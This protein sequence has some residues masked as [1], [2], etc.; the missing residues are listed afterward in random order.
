MPPAPAYSPDPD[1][2]KAITRVDRFYESG[3]QDRR[4]HEG[5]W[6][7]CTAAYRG[8]TEA[9][10]ND[11]EHRL[12]TPITPIRRRESRNRYQAKI[13]GRH[14]LFMRNPT[15]PEVRPATADHE[16]KQNARLTQKAL[17]YQ[18]RRCNVEQMYDEAL[19]WSELCSHGLLWLHWD[20]SVVVRGPNPLTQQVEEAQLGDIKLEVGS[21]FELLV[22]DPSIPYIGNQPAIMRCKIV[23]LD[24]LKAEYG[25][26]A[27]FI[28]PDSLDDD[29]HRNARYIA[30][31]AAGG[32]STA[33]TGQQLRTTSRGEKTS[34]DEPNIF[35]RVVRKEYFEAPCPLYP[36]G[37][38]AVVAGGVLLKE[39]YMLPEGF[40]D[41][42]NPYPV[43]DFPDMTVP[44]QF[45]GTTI[46]AQLL[47]TERGYNRAMDTIERNFRK[48]GAEKTVVDRRMKVNN[49]EITD[50]TNEVVVA[51]HLPGIPPIYK[52]PASPIIADAW[53]LIDVYRDQY[54][55]ISGIYPE[56]EGASGKSESGFQA[57]LLQEATSAIHQPD[58]NVHTR[59][60]VDLYRKMRRMMKNRYQATRLIS[61]GGHNS[62]PEVFEFSA[63]NIDEYADIVVETGSMLP[64]MK[65]ARLQ[66]LLELWGQGAF[67]PQNDPNAL[68]A[69]QKRLE[70]GRDD[71]SFDPQSTHEQNAHLENLRMHRGQDI[72]PAEFGDNHVLHYQIHVDDLVK[73]RMRGEPFQ[74]RLIRV[75][76]ILTHARYQNPQA[77][78]MIAAEYGLP[79]PPPPGAG[80]TLAANGAGQ[81]MPPGMPP[82]PSG[83]PPGGAPPPQGS[84]PQGPPGPPQG[85]PLD[86]GMA[87]PSAPP[88]AP[89]QF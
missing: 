64:D 3:Y 27:A 51:N 46:A 45:W 78:Q 73:A 83:M 65:G 16:D 15:K 69:F 7:L 48:A 20:P 66:A 43:I 79:V 17:E 58:I 29:T 41:M 18:D 82:G 34:E 10:W 6:F 86:P 4:P 9:R 36:Q 68:R 37:Y 54:D 49:A 30:G 13:R 35:D 60:K 81:G 76:H 70:F 77:A 14:A 11:F 55:V 52:L 5:E 88:Q 87:P 28:T 24:D 80:L 53:R 32:W 38:Y 56:A 31:L 85:P 71:E 33:V 39:E 50:E 22:A 59:A 26:L 75:K 44:G 84:V 63:S 1:Q 89:P 23:K 57:N 74:K 67:G 8:Q 72:E 25:E 12:I 40:G 21:P 61:I 62:E 19:H 47:S 42:A 2:R